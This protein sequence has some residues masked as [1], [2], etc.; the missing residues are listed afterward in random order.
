MRAPCLECGKARNIY[1]RGLCWDCWSAPAVRDRYERRHGGQPHV[2]PD[3]CLHCG[4]PKVRSRGLCLTCYENVDIRHRYPVIRTDLHGYDDG[5][6]RLPVLR[7]YP[8]P[9]RRER[10]E[11]DKLDGEC[12]FCERQQRATVAMIGGSSVQSEGEDDA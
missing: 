1:G 12:S 9:A 5:K 11:H 4:K 2:Q 6:A 3:A 7:T 8:D 10:C